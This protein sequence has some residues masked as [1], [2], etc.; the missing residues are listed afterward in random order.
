MLDKLF[1]HR[2]KETI[3]NSTIQL[4]SQRKDDVHTYM[5]IGH[6][7]WTKLT[8]HN[9]F[10]CKIIHRL[11]TFLLKQKYYNRIHAKTFSTPFPRL[12]IL[13]FGIGMAMFRTKFKQLLFLSIDLLICCSI[14]FTFQL[15]TFSFLP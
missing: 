5:C 14:S 7:Y 2:E 9:L 8:P 13:L 3:C 15:S 4:Y 1:R 11:Y 10:C 12:H 6:T